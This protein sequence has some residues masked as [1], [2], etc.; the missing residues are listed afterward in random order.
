MH[1]TGVATV[2]SVS[3]EMSQVQN[4]HLALLRG[5]TAQVWRPMHHRL[6]SE[7][8]EMSAAVHKGRPSVAGSS[9]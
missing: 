5:P 6:R 7:A 2:E 8:R 1:A 9:M 3:I 4:K